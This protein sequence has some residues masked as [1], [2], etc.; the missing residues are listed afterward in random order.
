MVFEREKDA[1]GQLLVHS[2]ACVRGGMPRDFALQAI[3][4]GFGAIDVSWMSV[5]SR[6][7]SQQSAADVDK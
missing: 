1:T 6:D 4:S 5:S 7:C 3:R 2:L